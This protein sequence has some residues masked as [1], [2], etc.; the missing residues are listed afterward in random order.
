VNS[1]TLI[2]GVAKGVR[3]LSCRSTVDFQPARAYLIDF[4]DEDD[5]LE[6]VQSFA[7]GGDHVEFRRLAAG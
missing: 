6:I 1:W 3:I 2:R 4:G 5:L 7:E